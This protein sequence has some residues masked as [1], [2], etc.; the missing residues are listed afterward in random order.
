MLGAV[1]CATGAIKVDGMDDT[2]AHV[3]EGGKA[4]F[5][6]DKHLNLVS[7]MQKKTANFS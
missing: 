2:F 6:P 3:F 5:I 4:K 1:V 7:T